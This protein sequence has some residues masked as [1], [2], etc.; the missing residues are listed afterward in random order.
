[1]EKK[2]QNYK[3]DKEINK[4]CKDN[5]ITRIKSMSM[6]YFKALLKLSMNIGYEQALKE[7]GDKE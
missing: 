6:H 3:W 4:L 5:G 2:R 1:M 7:L